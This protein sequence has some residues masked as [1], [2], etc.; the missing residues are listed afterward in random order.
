V[1]GFEAGVAGGVA[2]ILSLELAE[3]VALGKAA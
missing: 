2:F 1:A 3:G